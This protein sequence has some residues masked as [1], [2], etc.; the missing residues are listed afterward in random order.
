[1]FELR[2]IELFNAIQTQVFS[3][4][5]NT[6]DNAFVSG[7]V[8]CGKSICAELA[9]LRMFKT[10]ADV[11]GSQAAPVPNAKLGEERAVY[12]CARAEVAET[13]HRQWSEYL[14][15]LSKK[16]VL[17]TGDTST[18]LKL[19]AK[20]LFYRVSLA[21]PVPYPSPAFEYSIAV[22]RAARS[23]FFLL[24]FLQAHVVIS[25]PDKWDMLSRRWKQRKA[26]QTVHLFIVDDLHL[27]GSSSDGVCSLL[28]SIFLVPLSLLSLDLLQVPICIYNLVGSMPQFFFFMFVCVLAVCFTLLYHMSY[29][30]L[31]YHCTTLRS[32]FTVYFKPYSLIY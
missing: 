27:I 17:L 10:F 1:M 7:P 8:G 3:T 19:L 26:I 6:D 25:T 28:F 2:K 15:P 31:L 21:P 29:M 18:D 24:S 23:C 11:A 32:I 5:F 12:V 16:V 22:S 14:A 4:L 30:C 9:L 20:V 13:R